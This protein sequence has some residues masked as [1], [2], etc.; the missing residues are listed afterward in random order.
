MNN[1]QNSFRRFILLWTGEL[2][3]ATGSGITAFGIG[4]FV[5]QLT[6]KASA[7]SIAALLAF[8]PALLLSA[9]AG[10]LADRCDRRIL[11]I[12]GDGLSALGPA[13]ILFCM[14]T[15]DI[16]LWQI[17]TGVTM[18]SVFS[19][20]LE[21]SYKATITDLLSREQFTKASGL[22][23]VS[24]SARYLISPV[25]AGFLLTVADLRLLLIIDI[26]TFGVTIASTLAI[27]K[28]LKSG[29]S[30]SGNSF[31]S[32]FR[33]GIRALV[34]NTGILTLSL[35][36]S[37]LTFFIGFI[38]TLLTPMIISFSDSRAL[39]I[40][41]TVSASGMLAS[42]ILISIIPIKKAYTKI[43]SISL[44]MTGVFMFFFGMR[45]NLF[46]ITLS[47]FLFFCTLPFANTSIDYLLRTNIDNSLQGRVW[48]LIGLVSQFGYIIAYAVSGPLTDYVFTP[49]LRDGGLLSN[50]IGRITGTGEGRG[51]GLLIMISGILLSLTS[52]LLYSRKSIKELEVIHEA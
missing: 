8:L 41:E 49:L 51:A 3:S 6:G 32:D 30:A 44:F 10:T 24:G 40:A 48:G 42:G 35:I 4:I 36:G 13:F 45:E 19:S 1:T 46:L 52:I 14:Q 21:P 9:P 37:L 20:L 12:I 28:G 15:G 38:Q 31:H 50:S 29:R 11:M 22:V 18:S 34:N 2:I 43:L 17:Y 27:R 25:I 7:T 23:Q 39:G 26:S 16:K 47:G 5:Y 33:E